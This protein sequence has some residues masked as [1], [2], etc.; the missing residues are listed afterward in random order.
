[1]II[2]V[3]GNDT[4]EE[5]VD[6]VRPVVWGTTLESLEMEQSEM[7]IEVKLWKRALQW[8]MGIQRTYSSYCL[9]STVE[10]SVY[11]SSWLISTVKSSVRLT[12]CKVPIGLKLVSQNPVLG[13]RLTIE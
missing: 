10:S 1:M 13:C 6:E 11:S 5:D 4:N 3:L 7:R 9:I 2:G 12:S 8:T